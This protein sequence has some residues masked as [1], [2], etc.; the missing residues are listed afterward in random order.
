M[1]PRSSASISEPSAL[2]R[3][4]GPDLGAAHAVFQRALVGERALDA[5]VLDGVQAR[6]GLPRAHETAQAVT[7][8]QQRRE[9]GADEAAGAGQEADGRHAAA[10]LLTRLR[11][12]RSS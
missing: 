5:L 3:S 4:P 8:G 12:G 10:E 11:A 7:L 2:R 1:R 6:Q 9:I